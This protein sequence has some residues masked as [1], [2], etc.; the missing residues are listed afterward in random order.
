M[1]SQT[2]EQLRPTTKKVPRGR[3]QRWLARLTLI[4]V[5]TLLLVNLVFALVVAGYQIYYDGLIFPGVSVWEIDLSGMT[6]DEAIQ[7]LDGQFD[8]PQSAA[9]TFR[10][11]GTEWQVTAHD[12]GVGFDVSRTVQAAYEV[13]RQPD[14]LMSLR[15]QIASWREGVVVSPVIVYDQRIADVTLNQIAASINQPAVDATIHVDGVQAVATPGQIGRQVQREP[16]IEALREMILS[17][18]GGEVEVV[19]Q[20]T[21][22]QI[23][24]ADEAA[25]TINSIL[26]ADLEVRIDE[27]YEGDPGPWT[28]SRETLANMIIIDRVENEDGTGS[29]AVRLD[30][31]QLTGFLQPLETELSREPVD[32]RFDFDEVSR[33]VTSIVDSQEGR[34]LDVAASIQQINQMLMQGEHQVPLVFQTVEPAVPSTATA[35]ELGITELVSSSTT[36]FAG[37]SQ[38][39]R[40][41]VQVAAS[42]FHGVVIPPHSEFSFNQY[43]GDVSAESGFES[44]LII[45]NGRTIEGVGGGVCQVSTTAFQA[46]FYAGFPINERWSHGYW[47]GYYDSG[48]GKGMD[49]TV[50]SPLVDLRFTNDM[51]T[52]LLIETETNLSALTVTFRFY[53]TNDGR[54]VQKDGPYVNNTVPHG[55]SLYEENADLSPGTI[56]QVDYAVDGFDA[57]VYRSVYRDGELL[58]ND[59]FFSQYMPWQAIY[60]VPPGEM[61]SGAQRVGQGN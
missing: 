41:N 3:T 22:P 35:E 55:P 14:L 8:Y 36:Y 37:S 9:I 17:L 1:V 12:L 58:Y 20:E 25:A 10:D 56:K 57:T 7:A 42:R 40:D 24:S 18:Q 50:Y 6:P 32:A 45:Y 49:A 26:A 23:L 2:S 16:T 44:A 52:Y 48:E 54:T 11:G 28:A 43:L 21:P 5:S 19:V 39:R 59:T 15:Q 61:P 38:E 4:I 27:P 30:G 34:H 33:M 47:V 13:G 51:D 46:A 29:Y 31:N 53:S 60:Q